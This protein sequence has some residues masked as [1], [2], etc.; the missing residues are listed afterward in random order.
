MSDP[1]GGGGSVQFRDLMEAAMAEAM[2]L[3]DLGQLRQ[4]VA[5]LPTLMETAQVLSP[6][7]GQL[8]Q[9]LTQGPTPVHVHPP[10]QPA[11][12]VNVNVPPSR[13]PD[14]HL[15]QQAAPVIHNYPPAAPKRKG[16]RRAKV[17]NDDGTTHTFEMMDDSE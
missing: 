13:M 14:I 8:Q 3:P 9:L 4:L 5:A 2:G 17:T 15:P 1:T 10:A 11:P 6:H 16:H 7:L 12:V